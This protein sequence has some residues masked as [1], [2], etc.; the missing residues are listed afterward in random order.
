MKS[1][2]S[3]STLKLTTV[4]TNAA[5]TLTTIPGKEGIIGLNFSG[6]KSKS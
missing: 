2:F 4:G 3:K 5:R 1:Y 6:Q